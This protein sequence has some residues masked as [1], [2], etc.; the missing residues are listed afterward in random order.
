MD[1]LSRWLI[2]VPVL[3]LL[4][5][6]GLLRAFDPAPL[7]AVRLGYFDLQ[8]QLLPRQALGA[9][10]TIIDIDEASLARLGQWPWPR[11]VVADLLERLAAGRPLVLGLGVV[12]PEADRTSPGLPSH[13]E[14]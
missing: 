9:P 3:G 14:R 8:Q 6:L 10:V 5:A 12:F 1:R 7:I 13:D 11:D 2:V 4:L